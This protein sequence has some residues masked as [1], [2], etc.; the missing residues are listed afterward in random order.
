[1]PLA[2]Q[3]K[4]TRTVRC[5]TGSIGMRSSL[6]AAEAMHS[7]SDSE[8]SAAAADNVVAFEV[9]DAGGTWAAGWGVVVIGLAQ[10]HTDRF[11]ASR[12]RGPGWVQHP[13]VAEDSAS[14]RSS[15]A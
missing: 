11:A 15:S 12:A 8:H 9:D 6:R 10:E 5:P 3:Q 1:M 4:T 14:D 13:N 2:G 7:N